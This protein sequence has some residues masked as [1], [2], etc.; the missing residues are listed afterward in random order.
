MQLAPHYGDVVADVGAFLVE[1]AG[2]ARAAGIAAQRI[3]VD[4]GFGFGKGQE[5]NLELLRRLGEIARLG[6]PV[7]VGLSRKSML[8]RMTGQPVEKRVHASVAAALL[9]AINGA[10]ILR[11][12]DVQATRDALS[13]LNAVRGQASS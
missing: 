8:G 13:V 11:V 7:L 3:V 6:W 2:A 9:A 4:P 12:H 1:R 5:H 10:R